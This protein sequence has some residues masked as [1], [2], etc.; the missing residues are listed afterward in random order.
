[1][2]SRKLLETAL[3]VLSKWNKGWPPAAADVEVLRLHA[4]PEEGNLESDELACCIVRR[5]TGKRAPAV[6]S[7]APK[8]PRPPRVRRPAEIGNEQR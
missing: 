4:L 8:R 6:L 7:T 1:M 2:P 3:R 5:E